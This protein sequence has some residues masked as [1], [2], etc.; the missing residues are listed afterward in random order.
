M[1]INLNEQNHFNWV[2]LAMELWEENTMVTLCCDLL[3][4]ERCLQVEVVLLAEKAGHATI[5]VLEGT[6]WGAFC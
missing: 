4:Q 2:Q 3:F 6:Y 5:V 1:E